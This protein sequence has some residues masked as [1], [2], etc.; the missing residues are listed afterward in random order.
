M[1]LYLVQHGQAKAKED[2]PERPLTDQG[3]RDVERVAALLK[4]LDLTVS[5]VWHSGKTR[6]DQTAQLLATA[7]QADEGVVQRDGLAP[8]DPVG[9]VVKAL[10]DRQ[11]DLMIVGHMPFM[12]KLASALLAGDRKAAIVTFQQGGICCLQRDDAG[13]HVA[14]MVVPAVL[15]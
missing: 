5:A 13:W 6:A 1:K 10:A 9:P 11:A 2:D 15:T 7:I 12:A 8:K 3:R 4:P 14:W